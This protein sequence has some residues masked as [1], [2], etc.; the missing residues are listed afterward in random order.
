MALLLLVVAIIGTLGKS[1]MIALEIEL[2]IIAIST[3]SLQS[4]AWAA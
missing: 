4:A 3:S 1:W 2:F